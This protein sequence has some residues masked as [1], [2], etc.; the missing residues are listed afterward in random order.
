MIGGSTRRR[1]LGSFAAYF[2]SIHVP[3]LL[4]KTYP[5]GIFWSPGFFSSTVGLNEKQ[6]QQ[7][8]EFQGRED[9][10]TN[11]LTLC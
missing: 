8:V 3:H 9:R 10:N 2:V 6:I 5:R 7:Y 1:D 11:Q 4:K